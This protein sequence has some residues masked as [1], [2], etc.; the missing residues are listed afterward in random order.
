MQNCKSCKYGQI[1]QFRVNAG[2][3]SEKVNEWVT[4]E[5]TNLVYTTDYVKECSCYNR[6]LS[7]YDLCYNCEYY[8]GG[9]DWGLFCSHKEMYNHIGKFN[10]SPCKYYIKKR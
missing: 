9:S 2:S 4:C 8:L 6:D 5:L 7:G 3:G 10:D 1:G